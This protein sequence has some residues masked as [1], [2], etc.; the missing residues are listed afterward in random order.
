[1]NDKQTTEWKLS[2]NL[3]S[4]PNF[5]LKHSLRGKTALCNF[6]SQFSNFGQNFAFNSKF[7]HFEIWRP[8]KLLSVDFFGLD[9]GSKPV[10]GANK[11]V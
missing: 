11:P 8:P 6:L 5:T 7:V 3:I 4:G 10:S 9:H 2:E 1:M